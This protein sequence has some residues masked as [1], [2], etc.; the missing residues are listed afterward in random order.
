MTCFVVTFIVPSCDDDVRCQM[1]RCCKLQ[2]PRKMA[3]ESDFR[4]LYLQYSIRYVQID[5]NESVLL[6]CS[7]LE[8][9]DKILADRL[10]GRHS[11]KQR[12]DHLESTLLFTT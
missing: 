6:A 5:S 2:T 1:M 10:T 3:S 4:L 9:Y 7:L 11:L 8:L 12:A